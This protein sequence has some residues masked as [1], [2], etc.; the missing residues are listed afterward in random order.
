MSDQHDICLGFEDLQEEFSMK[1][2]HGGMLFLWLYRANN[3]IDVG[4]L[5]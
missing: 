5:V 3:H 1:A 2:D 4:L